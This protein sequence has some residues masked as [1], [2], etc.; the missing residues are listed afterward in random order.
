MKISS[1]MNIHR[2]ILSVVIILI[3]ASSCIF[4]PKEGE[5]RPNPP[6][7][8]Q[9]PITPDIV[10]ENMNVAFNDLDIDFYERCIHEDYF[11]DSPS[12]ID[13]LSVESWSRSTDVRVM[14]NIFD[15]CTS[16]VYTP[17]YISQVKE[18]G[19]NV[20]DIP[21]GAEISEG[22]P[23]QIWYKYNYNISIDLYSRKYGELKVQQFMI[24]IFVEDPK[25]HWSIIRWIDETGLTD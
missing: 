3:I 5:K 21:Q 9:E 4:A 14:G 18:Y 23:N 20:P 11:Y 1:Y 12:E 25:N 17:I 15:D 22:H 2:L 24:Y 6:G 10:V 13:S 16:I 8:W 7:K 19:K